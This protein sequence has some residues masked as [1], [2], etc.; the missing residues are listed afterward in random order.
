MLLPERDG[1][2]AE[3]GRAVTAARTRW[4]HE[5][6]SVQQAGQDG[7]R[8]SYLLV[9]VRMSL[10]GLA[11]P[12]LVTCGPT[13]DQHKSGEC[14]R[15]VGCRP[16]K[17][18]DLLIRP[19]TVNLGLGE[20]A[21]IDLFQTTSVCWRKA[22]GSTP[23]TV[24]RQQA[25]SWCSGASRFRDWLLRP[26]VKPKHVIALSDRQRYQHGAR[27]PRWGFASKQDHSSIEDQGWRYRN[28]F[29]AARTSRE[30]S[31]PPQC[32]PR[33]YQESGGPGPPKFRYP[34]GKQGSKSL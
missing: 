34:G 28:L 13:G 22:K 4:F 20:I 21:A 9:P 25:E 2:N 16:G 6:P 18:T 8:I 27:Y 19:I 15:W 24:N 10:T 14:N 7:S 23:E 17:A 29:R 5:G 30:I 26:S 31:R 33:S 12:K 11:V 32:G 1:R 3:S